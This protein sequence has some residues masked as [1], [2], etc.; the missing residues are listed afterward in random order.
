MSALRVS[1]S[2]DVPPVGKAAELAE[3]AE[4][5]TWALPVALLGSWT[6]FA[7]VP[8]LNW[9]LWT[10]AAAAGALAIN[11]RADRT[12]AD[13][14]P[15]A[16]LILAC[17]LSTAA[18]ITASPAADALVFLCVAGLFAF[19]LLATV[20]RADEIGPAAL[21]RTPLLMGRL[22][23]AEAAARI[24]DTFAALRMR[25]ALPLVRGGILALGL[26]SVL[27]LL[28]S[29]ADPT[30]ADW[31][32]IAWQAIHT[33]TFVARDLFFVVLTLLLLGAYGLAARGPQPGPQAAGS[34]ARSAAACAV[35]FSDLE[36]LIV[37]GAALVLLMVF[38]AAEL[39]SRLAS[40][41]I[42]LPAGETFAEATHRG[43]GEMILAAALCAWA[44]TMLEQRALRDRRETPVRLLSWGLT[45][46]SLAV[47]AS[48]YQRVRYYEM[49]YGYTEQRLYVQ[50]CCAAVAAA[51]LLLAWE[52]RSSI[53]LPRLMRHAAL[54]A[55]ACAA[56]LSFWNSAAWIVDANVARYRST[57]KLDVSYLERLAQAS[58]DAIP[59][60]V[61]ALPR[62]AP[63]DARQVR[64]TLLML[65]AGRAAS[66][67]YEWS[68]RRAAARSALREAGLAAGLSGTRPWR[69][70]ADPHARSA[71]ASASTRDAPATDL[72]AA[73]RL[74][75]SPR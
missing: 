38:F 25:A 28:L 75:H 9:T 14:Y 20:S 48:A 52:L 50:V 21:A 32:D 71:A 63:S 17:L 36:R 59:A 3:L 41:G 26:A 13:R 10:V 46:A 69:P 19:S 67:W 1:R 11:R 27:F 56:G 68:L 39:S 22:L 51:L 47:V 8:G 70:S 55:M 66:S 61:A 57:G 35:R 34:D 73:G 5:W 74:G 44:I 49:A 43:F 60:L 65:R 42:H 30:M 2:A 16:A 4:L 7:A 12:H 18:A 58:P 6:C 33:W 37:L 62:L 40:P 72:T 23:F 64:T 31:R 45:G 53:R 54:A 29:A 24:A 15:R